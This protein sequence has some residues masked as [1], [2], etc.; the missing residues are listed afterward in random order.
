MFRLVL[1]AL[2]Q[3]NVMTREFGY[4]DLSAGA[5]PTRNLRRFRHRRQKTRWFRR[6]YRQTENHERATWRKSHDAECR[7]LRSPRRG[8][9]ANFCWPTTRQ[10]ARRRRR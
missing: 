5:G 3:R 9:V 6:W 2:R 1:N 8:F 4:E 7:S 10:V